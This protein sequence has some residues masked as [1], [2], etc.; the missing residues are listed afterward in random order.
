MGAGSAKERGRP[1][2]DGAGQLAGDRPRLGARASAE[3]PVGGEG[4]EP[5]HLFELLEA[6]LPQVPQ[7]RQAAVTARDFEPGERVEVDYAGDTLEWVEPSTGEIRKAFVFVAGLGFSQLLFAWA[8]AD[9]RS[10]NW[11]GC[12]RRMFAFYG[13]VAS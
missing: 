11:P 4:A 8:A 1:T 6:V 12:H 3:V 10:A 2:V 13:G 5:H 9:T 7:Y